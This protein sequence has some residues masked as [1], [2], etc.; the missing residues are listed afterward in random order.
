MLPLFRRTISCLFLALAAGTAVRAAETPKPVSAICSKFEAE[1]TGNLRA[2]KVR[3][4][5]VA[6]SRYE[7][8][9]R[10]SYPPAS[11]ADNVFQSE[12]EH[13]KL[14]S[15]FEG[16]ARDAAVEAAVPDWLPTLGFDVLLVLSNKDG[17]KRFTVLAGDLAK[18]KRTSGDTAV[19]TD[20]ASLAQCAAILGKEFGNEKS[21]S[22]EELDGRHV[23]WLELAG[24]PGFRLEVLLIPNAGK[25]YGL[26][27]TCPLAEA[28]D[29]RDKLRGIYKTADFQYKPSDRARIAALRSQVDDAGNVWQHLKCIHDLVDIGEY[30][31]ACIDLDRL[32]PLLAQRIPKPK[33]VNREIRYESYGISLANPNP[34]VWRCSVNSGAAPPLMFL[35]NTSSIISTGIMVSVIDPLVVYGAQADK[36]LGRNAPEGLKKSMLSGGVEGGLLKISE[37]IESER[38]TTFRGMP[39]CEGVA[40]TNFANAKVKLICALNDRYLLMV[41]LLVDAINPKRQIAE[42]EALLQKVLRLEAGPLAPSAAPVQKRKR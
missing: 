37:R 8:A 28:G 3:P 20:E 34:K 12:A 24:E 16:W 31:D 18:V 33:I 41:M 1:I 26:I 9:I 25:V 40:T 13:L 5:I 35:E 6:C 14:T 19:V 2:G 21:R 38:F 10:A 22:A 32:L 39:A 7:A 29:M 42:Y 11:F 23:L 36:F 30:R 4:A 17:E 15:P 27:G